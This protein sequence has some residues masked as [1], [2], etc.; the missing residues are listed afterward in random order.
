MIR[1]SKALEAV[2]KQNPEYCVKRKKKAFKSDVCCKVKQN[3]IKVTEIS[4][5][6]VNKYMRIDEIT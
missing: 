3:K 4:E 6:L 5:W 1:M 2:L